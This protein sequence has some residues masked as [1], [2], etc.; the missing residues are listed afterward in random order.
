MYSPKI[1]DHFIPTLHHLARLRGQRMTAVVAEAI[2]QYVARQ[3]LAPVADLIA[4]SERR[5]GLPPARRT[6]AP[7]HDRERVV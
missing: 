1:P 3:D 4:A 6:A 2:E 5:Y 7:P